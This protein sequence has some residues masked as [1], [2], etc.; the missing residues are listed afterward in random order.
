MQ[1]TQTK[2]CGCCIPCSQCVTS[3]VASGF[4]LRYSAVVRY[5]AEFCCVPTQLVDQNSS[6][7]N[8]N[9]TIGLMRQPQAIDRDMVQSC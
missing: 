4:S 6:S 7:D 5:A 3:L 2:V 8:I 9:V 1:F